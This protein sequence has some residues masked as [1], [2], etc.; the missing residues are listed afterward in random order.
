MYPIYKGTYERYLASA[1][2]GPNEERDLTIQW[3]KDVSRSI[4]YIETRTDLDHE[5]LAFFGVILGADVAPIFSAVESRFKTSILQSGGLSSD[6]ALAAEANAINFLPRVKIPVLMM[7]GRDDFLSPLE[8][9]QIPMFRFLGTPEK[10]K[11]HT[12]F[13]SGHV[14][15]RAE[16]IKEVL[17]WLNHYLGPVK[18]KER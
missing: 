13:D 4:D 9:S 15:P 10:E 14:L 6:T 3:A 7:N 8:Q 2:A 16:V 11:R 18:L 5:R 17:A 1:L 12:L